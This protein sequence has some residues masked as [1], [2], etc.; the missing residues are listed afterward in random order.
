M[1]IFNKASYGDPLDAC[2]GPRPTYVIVE[3]TRSYPRY[4]L[5]YVEIIDIPSTEA[6]PRG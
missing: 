5:G 3:V 4:I 6:I 2:Q 1:K